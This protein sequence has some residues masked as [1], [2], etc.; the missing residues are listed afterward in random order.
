MYKFTTLPN[1]R[2]MQNPIQAVCRQHRILGT[3]LLAEEGINGTVAGSRPAIDALVAHLKAYPELTELEHK[4]SYCEQM[5]FKRLK[6]RPK[7]ELIT[8][9][10]PSVDPRSKVGTYVDPQEWN[11]LIS[12]PDVVLIDTRNDYEIA[13]GT[14]EGAIDPN[15]ESFTEFPAYVEQNLDREKHRKIAMFCTGGIRCEKATSFLLDQGFEEVYHLKG[16]ILKYLEEIPPDQSTWQGE[17]YVFDDRVSVDHA[18]K[19]GHYKMCHG[20]GRPIREEDL[21]SGKYELGVSCPTCYDELTED[22]LKRFRERQRQVVL[23][24]KRNQIHIGDR[25]GHKLS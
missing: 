20:C 19:P 14:F 13:I 18:L 23:A 16:G 22:Q 8:L 2:E 3:L 7:A 1:Y 6:V 12:D 25:F 15:T 17:C 10:D 9:G 11:T 4:E 21:S 24:Q 5:P